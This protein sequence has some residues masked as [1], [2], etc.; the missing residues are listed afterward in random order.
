MTKAIKFISNFLRRK[1]NL[2]VNGSEFIGSKQY[3]ENRYS[4]GGTSGS[5]S[6]GQLAMF[7]ARVLNAFVND[8]QV[9]SVIEFGCGDGNQLTLAEY[10]RY[11]GL[12]VSETAVARCKEL[13]KGDANKSFFKMSNME[14]PAGLSA[15]LTLSLDV[16]YHLVEDN[17]FNEYMNMLFKS[18]TKYVIIYSSNFDGKQHNHERTRNFTRWIDENCKEWI[19]QEKIMNQFPY[20]TQQENDSSQSDFYVYT[21]NESGG[22]PQV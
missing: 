6:Y 3:W 22:S 20:S 12:D 21:K 19:L 8:K 1:Y 5:G 13:F 7:K 9:R 16:I 4:M 15:E 14:H 17:V 11:T 10:P 18:S 2:L